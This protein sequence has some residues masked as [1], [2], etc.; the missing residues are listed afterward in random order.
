MPRQTTEGITLPPSKRENIRDTQKLENWFCA[1]S[2]SVAMRLIYFTCV[3]SAPGTCQAP[4]SARVLFLSYL[5]EGVS[6][7][8]LCVYV[9]HNTYF[10]IHE[11]LKRPSGTYRQGW[12]QAALLNVT[13][14][15]ALFE[16]HFFFF[17]FTYVT[18]SP[19]DHAG[20]FFPL[21]SHCCWS[22]II[23]KRGLRNSTR[24]RHYFLPISLSERAT[25]HGR[26]ETAF[27]VRGIFITRKHLLLPPFKMLNFQ[28]PLGF[29]KRPSPLGP[30]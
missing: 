8:Y 24:G 1:T 2:L 26:G 25:Y 18:A 6:Y 14:V 7:L 4:C 30:L 28:R 22:S 3:H 19:E 27:K 12:Q 17:F 15:T 5:L 20:T 29:K 10:V 13:I 21:D 9:C 11:Q 23:T 16:L